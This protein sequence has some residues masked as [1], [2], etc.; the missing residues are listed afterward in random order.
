[1]NLAKLSFMHAKL[2]YNHPQFYDDSFTFT[3]Q[4]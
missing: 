3:K 2:V 4:Y 1:M